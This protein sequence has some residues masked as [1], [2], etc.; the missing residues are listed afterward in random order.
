MYAA[1]LKEADTIFCVVSGQLTPLPCT[2]AIHRE[3][4]DAQNLSISTILSI[5]KL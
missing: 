4:L 5:S 2:K 3:K 1:G